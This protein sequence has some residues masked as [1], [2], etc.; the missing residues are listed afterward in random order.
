VEAWHRRPGS[1]VGHGEPQ[2]PVQD[3]CHKSD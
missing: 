2:L 1:R 3:G